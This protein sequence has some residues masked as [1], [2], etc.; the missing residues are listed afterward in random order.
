MPPI[1]LNL[2]APRSPAYNHATPAAVRTRIPE[3]LV[4]LGFRCWITGLSSGDIGAWEEAW[5][6]YAQALGVERA[7]S[8]VLDLSH[9]ARAVHAT[10]ERPIE[11]QAPSCRG[12]CRDECLAISVIAACQHNVRDALQ[13][14]C[15]ALIGSEDIGDTLIGAQ[16]FACCLKSANQVLSAE[17]VCPATC[18]L[19]IGRVLN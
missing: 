15:A 13:A 12:F 2:R 10:S 14:S 8:A 9:F 18:A 7:K 19:R 3:R 16:A 1:R 6:T 11:V 17:S 5:S 4:G